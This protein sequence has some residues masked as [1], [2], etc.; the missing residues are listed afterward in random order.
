M[1]PAVR[2]TDLRFADDGREVLD[3]H[4][5]FWALW[6][7]IRAVLILLPA[8]LRLVTIG[9]VLVFAGLAYLMAQVSLRGVEL[10]VLHNLHVIASGR[11]AMFKELE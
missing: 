1:V 3:G 2:V 8:S 7:P 11:P 5:I 9:I 10:N 4:D 6:F